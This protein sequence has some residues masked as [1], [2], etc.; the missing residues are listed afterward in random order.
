MDFVVYALKNYIEL[1]ADFGPELWPDEP[2]GAGSQKPQTVLNN[3]HV[4]CKPT[5]LPN[6]MHEK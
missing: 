4:L 6:R 5:Y 3:F 2:D 1:F